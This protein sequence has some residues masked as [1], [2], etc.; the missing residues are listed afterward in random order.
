VAADLHV[1]VRWLSV[2]LA[3]IQS[4]WQSRI[5]LFASE[6]NAQLPSFVSWFPQ[7]N[8]QWTDAFSRDWKGLQAYAF[9]PFNLIPHFLSKLIQ[10]QATLTLITPYWPSQA[11]F[12]TLLEL[13]S[14]IPM[15]PHPMPDLHTS[16]LGQCHSEP[17]HSTDRLTLGANKFKF[18]L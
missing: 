7:P 12:P 5:D 13:L 11:W 18:C 1:F 9:P 10:D 2:S 17:I 14:E 6:W 4:I 16:P 8:A 15:V 3:Q